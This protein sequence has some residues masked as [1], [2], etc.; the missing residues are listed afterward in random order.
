MAGSKFKRTIVLGLDYSEISG[1]TAEITRKMG[2]LD[3][4]FG[5][6]KEQAKSYGEVTDEL[7]VKSQYLTQKINLKQKALDISVKKYKEA[8]AAGDKSEKTLDAMNKAIIRQQTELEKLNRELKEND[9]KLEETEKSAD[10]FGETIRDMA[11]MLG[12]NAC[13]AVQNFAA[14]F[15]EVDAKVGAAVLTIGTLVTTLGTLTLKT[16]EN[17]KEISNTAQ[18]M[19]MT[20]DQYQ[21][22]DYI[23]KTVGYDAESAS[24]DLAQLGEKAMDAAEGAGEG[25]EL[26]KK[27]GIRVKDSSGELKSQNELF[28]EVIG[29]LQGMADETKRNAIASALLSTTGEK[30]VPVLNMTKEE[31]AA[32]RQEAHD[33][34][35]VMDAQQIKKF[36][37]LNEEMDELKRIGE[38]LGNTFAD[39]LLPMLTA[40]FSAI[41][42]IPAPV[43]Q[44]II[45]LTAMIGTMVV[46]GK[47]VS[48]AYKT[49]DTFVDKLAGVDDKTLKTTAIVFGIVAALIALAAIITVLTGKGDDLQKT[50]SSVGDSVGNINRNIQ[51][52]QRSNTPRYN[53]RGTEYFE[54]GE[55]WVGEHGPEKVK[56]PTGSRIISNSESRSS[57]NNYYYITIDAKNVKD[58]NRVVEIVDGIERSRRQGGVVNA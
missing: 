11:D 56:L 40:L 6:V 13:P 4:Q 39:A 55:T 34:G 57:R 43:L 23:L 33:T 1:G 15:D 45:Q 9:E 12:I 50:M 44:M 48:S 16:A 28:T 20:T 5:L 52:T 41:S 54:G 7:S 31:F 18:T 42:A 8:K 47:A 25:A 29:K 10:S 2:L 3:A 49:F 22:W 51:T 17:A 35:Y 27:L 46:V 14:H 53:A 24:G 38:G 30:L 37:K 32:L 19:G 58:F 36:R 26:F 21:E